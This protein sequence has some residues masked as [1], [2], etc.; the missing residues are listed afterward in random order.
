VLTK[1][2]IKLIKSLKHRK[3][4]VENNLFVIEGLKIINEFINSDW[5][6]KKIFLTNDTDL[7]TNLNLNY[8]SNSD[9]KRIS[10]LKTPNKILALVKIPKLIKNIKGKLIIAL[11]GVQDPGNL[12]SIIRLADWFGVS[13][14][15]CSKNC[16]DVYNP[17]VVQSTMGSILRVSVNYVNLIKEIQNLSKYKLFSSVLDGRNINDIDI[18][19]NSIILFGNESKGI[20]EELI[21]LSKNK[22]SIPKLSSSKINSLNV[23]NACAIV[24]NNFIR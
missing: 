20:S 10:F 23:S 4:R 11:D 2:D 9:L 15:L 14:I 1:N 5:E 7:K 17:K 12:G 13:N 21:S 6:V 24:L 22:I 8:I 3:H 18:N 19:G 16:V